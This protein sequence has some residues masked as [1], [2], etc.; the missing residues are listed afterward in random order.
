MFFMMLFNEGWWELPPMIDAEILNKSRIVNFIFRS[1]G[2]SG[3]VPP[4]LFKLNNL[5][6]LD[7]SD[8]P[9]E[10]SLPDS[11]GD[12]TSLEF[13]NLHAS[14]LNGT[15][16]ASLGKLANIDAMILE[17]NKFMGPLPP[18]LGN[19]SKLKLLDLGHNELEGT[20]PS[21]FSSLVSLEHISLHHNLDLHGPISAFE[22]LQN[23]SS[24][25]LYGN[26]FSSTLP[27]GL[28]SGAAGPKIIADLG[29]NSF[30]GDLPEA[31]SKYASNTSEPPVVLPA[32]SL[33]WSLINSSSAVA[34]S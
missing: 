33:K 15:L 16:P 14:N 2:L 30:V 23:L 1:S 10:G 26:A 9:M 17:G 32:P 28:F 5:E 22:S 8:N 13:L 21:T 7:L 20:V 18:S 19:L 6:I 4:Y 27:E 12:S 25:A 11:I 34:H 24:L 29:H 31:L 3:T